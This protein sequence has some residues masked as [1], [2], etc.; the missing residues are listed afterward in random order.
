M[1]SCSCLH[2]FMLHI[3]EQC[4]LDATAGHIMQ[5]PVFRHDLDLTVCVNHVSQGIP[6]LLSSCT[7]P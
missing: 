5:R 2:E 6:V 7:L 4:I 1:C 3:A